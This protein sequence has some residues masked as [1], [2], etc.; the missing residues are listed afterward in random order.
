MFGKNDKIHT[1]PPEKVRKNVKTGWKPL[2][3][4]FRIFRD[5]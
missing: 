1:E 4:P 3:L 5:P 2:Y